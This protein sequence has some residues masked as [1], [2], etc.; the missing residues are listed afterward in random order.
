MSMDKHT[1]SFHELYKSYANDIF[2]YAFYLT[3]S[4][5]DADDICSET[6]YRAWV[7]KTSLR[8]PTIK[9]YLFTIARN[10]YLKSLKNK[11]I[12]L[13]ETLMNSSDH[14][15]SITM[16]NQERISLIYRFLKTF[17]ELDRSA[18]TLR[19]NENL[20]YDEI[21]KI[22]DISVSMVKIKIFRLRQKIKDHCQEMEN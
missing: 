1:I 9:S 7:S 13:K 20:S 11:T 19:I 12:E 21:S 22:L 6:F 4:S 18:F 2:R 15:I 8:Y 17:P 16:E 3:G 5:D 14:N 10:L